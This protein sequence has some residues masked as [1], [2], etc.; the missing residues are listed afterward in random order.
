MSKI[1]K[2]H[3]QVENIESMAS[4]EVWDM[5]A[6]LIYQFREAGFDDDDIEDGI[7]F[8]LEEEF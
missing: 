6:E 4:H 1:I 7:R 2:V 5:V 3:G 8:A